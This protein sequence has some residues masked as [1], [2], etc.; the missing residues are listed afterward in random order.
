LTIASPSEAK[1]SSMASSGKPESDRI[2][3]KLKEK[4]DPKIAKEKEQL[5][6]DREQSQLEKAERRLGELV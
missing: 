6:R 2:I 5:L 4:I 3:D 1:L